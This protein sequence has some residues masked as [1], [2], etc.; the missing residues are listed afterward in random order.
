M[1]HSVKEDLVSDVGVFTQISDLKLPSVMFA[2]KSINA[3]KKFS[4]TIF[5]ADFIQ[6]KNFG[7][8]HHLEN[9][10]M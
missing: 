9:Q 8:N 4:S 2:V 5:S 1:H 7:K 6:I 3:I 10:M